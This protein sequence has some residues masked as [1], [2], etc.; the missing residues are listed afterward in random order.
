MTT[1]IDPEL[2][3][4]AV[5]VVSEAGRLTLD[6]F[7]GADLDVEEKGDGS[8]V[9]VAD[10]NAERLMRR[11]IEERFPDDSIHGE[12]E[13]DKA[14]SS[15]RRWVIDPIDGTISFTHGVGLYTNLLYMEDEHGP[16]IGVINVPAMG[17][18][19]AAG[20]GLGCRFNGQ[21][22]H[23]NDRSTVRG[24]VLSTSGFDWWEADRLMRAHGSG[25]I[26]RTWGDGYGFVL[27]ATGRIEA[28]VDPSIHYWDIA[29]CQVIIPE[30]GGRWS[31]LDGSQDPHHGSFIATNGVIHDELLEILG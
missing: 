26:L 17:E 3:D 13:A 16:A 15:G 10:R 12:E 8:P 11:M 25:A 29:P 19:V 14:G 1:P 24:S 4:F 28:M 5:E 7:R 6:L 27:V 31:A 22:C 9:T 18:M 20:R 21:P 23:V 2:L 30:A